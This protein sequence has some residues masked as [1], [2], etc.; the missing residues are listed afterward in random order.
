[1]SLTDKIIKNTAYHLLS[2]IIGIFFP[3]ILTPFIIA[4]IGQVEFGIYALVLGLIGTFGL[5]DLSLS[6]SF[7][8]FISEHYNRREFDELNKTINTGL[9]FYTAFSVIICIAAF[10]FSYQI[11]RFINIPENLINTSVYALR[12]GLL[13]FF[14]AT[15]ST[16]F[17]SVLISLQKMYINSILGLIVNFLNFCT[18]ILLLKL[19]YG[20]NGVLYSQLG[21]VTLSVLINIILAKRALPEMKISIGSLNFPSFKKMSNIGIQ[22]Q[23]SKIAGFLTDKYDEFLL[24]YFS[25]LNNVTFFNLAGRITRFGKFFPLQLFQQV[26]PAAAELNAKDKKDKLNQLFADST[27]YL[28]LASLPI[29][30]YIFT[31]AD[32][33]ILTW[34]GDGYTISVYLLRILAIGQVLN[35]MISAPGN[36][37]IPNLGIP[38]YQMYEGLIGLG[39]NI[40]LSYLFIK[41][42]GILGAAIGNTIATIISSIYVYFTSTAFFKVNRFQFTLRSY[43]FPFSVCLLVGLVMFLLYQAAGTEISNRLTGI[44]YILLT[45]VIFFSLYSLIILKSKYTT[46]KDM[47]NLLRF[48]KLIFS[49]KN[50]STV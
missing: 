32:L 13:I 23:V 33:I 20:L 40:I 19:G 26:A 29:F 39:L 37:I 4:S 50:E 21:T 41:Y 2:Q 1:M 35:L 15:S 44:I 14:L 9:F 10:A 42:Y 38:K 48:K 31:F 17:V 7:I 49:S 8:K 24:S 43:F 22:M 28:T 16:I 25:V 27:K 46:Q 3:I 12:I 34:M 18:T 47:E 11:V 6:T 5:F 30:F 45:G 36:S